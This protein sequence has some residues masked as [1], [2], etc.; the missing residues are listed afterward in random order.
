MSLKKIE[1]NNSLP[2]VVVEVEDTTATKIYFL[3]CR[4]S[5]S[6]KHPLYM[7]RNETLLRR[8]LFTTKAES[9]ARTYDK[10][11]CL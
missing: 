10:R 4:L 2:S 9:C 3:K 6:F 11:L 7:S 8:C 1:C 5:A